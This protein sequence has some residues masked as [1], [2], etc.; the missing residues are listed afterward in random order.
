MI[1]GS[2][3][4]GGIQYEI[5][6]E[7]EPIQLCHCQQCQKAQGTPLATN[8]PVSRQAFKLIAGQALLREFESSPGKF[9]SFC[10][11]CG[12]P[13]MSRRDSAPD[14]VRIRAGTIDKATDAGLAFHAYVASKAPWWPINDTL[15][16]FAGA[17]PADTTG[18]NPR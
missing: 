3:L 15:P 18:H 12:A 2:C 4:C 8:T 16:Q 9:R 1:T 11:R 14:S 17:A 13:I 5:H 7:L 10:S 6:A